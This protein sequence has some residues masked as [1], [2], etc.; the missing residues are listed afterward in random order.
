MKENIKAWVLPGYL[1]LCLLLGGASAAGLWANVLLQALAIALLLW[2]FAGEA[3]AST[4]KAG[5]QLLVLT[6][7]TV[8]IPLVQL[9]PLPPAIW[10]ALPGRESVATGFGLAGLPL[11]WLSLS[12]APFRTLASLVWMLPALAVLVVIIR[13]GAGDA[14]RIGF[15]ILTMMAL[16]VLAGA[17]QVTGG[18]NSPW[19]FYRI[20]N[21]GVTVGF[22][23]N[24]NHMAT[25]LVVSLPFLAALYWSGSKK[26]RP[27]RNTGARSAVAGGFFLLIVVGL[28]INGSLAGLGLIFPVTAASI[29][30]VMRRRPPAWSLAL[31]ALLAAGSIAAVFSGAFDNNLIAPEAQTSV[32]SRYTTFTRSFEAIKDYFPIGSGVGTFQSIYHMYEDPA[33]VTTTYINHVHSDWIEW[34]LETGL[35]G[36]LVVLLFLCWWGS[37]TIQI[38]RSPTP[39]YVTRAA[40]IATGTIMVHSLVDYPLRTAAISAIFAACCGIMAN[41]R[42]SVVRQRDQRAP[43]R[44]TRHLIAD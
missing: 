6:L 25:L 44:P 8:A 13:Q 4:A 33:L 22:F 14:A 43:M 9:I 24:A 28:F 21:Y 42:Q 1:S 40:T 7:L 35:P 12:L 11:P 10:T 5:R 27:G 18:E 39:Y 23:A 19:Y 41:S 29:L 16:S 3:Q 15:A 31:V 2:A 30:M 26:D 32:V 38:W 37:R 20:T 34:V 17:M 36:V